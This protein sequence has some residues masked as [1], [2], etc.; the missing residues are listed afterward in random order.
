MELTEKDIRNNIEELEENIN[1]L[2]SYDASVYDFVNKNNELTSNICDA[3]N[4]YLLEQWAL[5]NNGSQKIDK[6]TLSKAKIC[7]NAN[8]Y[9][10][11]TV[12]RIGAYNKY[13]PIY[14][15]SLNIYSNTHNDIDKNLKLAKSACKN[16]LSWFFVGKHKK[17]EAI[18][19]ANEVIHLIK[20]TSYTQQIDELKEKYSNLQNSD[21]TEDYKKNY[22]TYSKVLNDIVNKKTY[23]E[24]D[25][26]LIDFLR[27]KERL[28]ILYS[29]NLELEGKYNNIEKYNNKVIGAARRLAEQEALKVLRG[30]SIDELNTKGKKIRVSALKNSGYTCIADLCDKDPWEI[31]MIDGISEDTA[32]TIRS[33]VMDFEK[34]TISNQKLKLSADNK[35]KEATLLLSAVYAYYLNSDYLNKINGLY[36]NYDDKINALY[37]K[38]RYFINKES[39]FT[40]DANEKNN[41]VNN[42][43]VIDTI[44]DSD[45]I[46]QVDSLVEKITNKRMSDSELWDFFSENSANVFSILDEV[47]PGYFGNSDTFYGLPEDLA[48]EIKDECIFPDG[49]LCTLRRYQEWGVKYILHQRNVLLG[50]EMGLGKTIQAIAT[51]VSLKNTGAKHFIVVCPASVVINWCR[52]IATHSKLRVIKVHGNGK[53]SSLKA[54]IKRGGV[55]V[56]TYETTSL[57]NANLSEDF[58]YSLLVVDEAHYVKNPTARRSE[59]VV[60]L[61]KKADRILYMTGTALENKVDEMIN[62][63]G[64]LQPKIAYSVE[65]V[66]FLSTAE[67]FR[68]KIAPVYYRRKREDVLTELPDLIENKDWITLTDEERNKYEGNI[69]NKHYAQ[70]RRM[71][72]DIDDVSKSSKGQRLL[73]IIEDA[74]EDDRKVIIFSF[75]LDTIRAIKQLL[76]NK[77]L[78]PITGSLTPQRRQ[79]IIDELSESPAGTAIV[80]QIQAGGTGLNIQ[81]ASVIVIVEP[82]FKPSI[83]NQAISRAYRMGQTRNVQVHRLL[84]EKT[85][86]EKI[87]DLLAQKQAEF[88][89]FADESVAAKAQGEVEINETSFG[90]IIKEEI[91]RINRERGIDPSNEKKNTKE[92]YEY[93][94]QISEMSYDTLVDL[95]LKKYGKAE[96]DYFSTEECKSKNRKVV[97]SSEGLICHHIDEDKAI[98]L[99]NDQIAQM[100]SFEYQKADR[101]VYCNILEHMVLHLRIMDEK[102]KLDENDALYGIG[103]IVNFVAKQLN[104]FYSGKIITQ[105]YL[106]NEMKLVENDYDSY[107]MLLNKTW[108][109]I[110]EKGLDIRYSK[111]EL[112][113]GWY[114]DLYDDILKAI[115]D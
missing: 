64:N 35:S 90:E 36:R 93:Y 21:Y 16:G 115:K 70:A 20:E 47:V 27:E 12:N 58:D 74:K 108:K 113:L 7:F 110:K 42:C 55:A 71:S 6:E 30:I 56:T 50:D 82:Q 105:E 78:N 97:R 40:F 44:Y 29:K 98:M 106:N 79:E 81:S 37:S 5:L 3:F 34:N 24:N 101:L 77:C 87:A 53:A 76:G 65:D 112:A 2:A 88:D 109:I 38:T 4:S 26:E 114:E 28:N 17:E 67:I 99:S 1:T 103:G 75:F 48:D 94:K 111:E 102:L 61:S 32:Y 62:L 89:A 100:Y 73:E 91:E 13:N 107:I 86:E 10:A 46:N 60:Q 83:E 66:K 15:E 49:L 85:I 57:F 92:N 39:W 69:L 51:M 59:N 19:A 41:L 80:S 45:F 14:E 25:P 72:W 22:Y 23:V 11:N 31:S 54:W 8:K 95:L 43:R 9:D 104:D 68:Q 52:E 33:I 84:C 96:Y 63:I 18:R